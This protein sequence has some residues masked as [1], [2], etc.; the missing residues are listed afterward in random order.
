VVLM[1]L[2]AVADS[3]RAQ[4]PVVLLQIR[5]RAGDTLRVRLDQ[6]VEVG[7]LGRGATA[8]ATAT[9]TGTLV[10]HATL[11]IESVD[12]EGSTVTTVTDSVRVNTPPNSASAAVLS[13]AAAAVNRAVRFRIAP[14]GSASVPNS[15][16]ELPPAAVAAQM[17]ATLPRTPIAPGA[18]WTARMEVPMA[19][20]ADPD[21]RATLAATFAL[22]SLSRSGELAFISL[23]G[24]LIKTEKDARA[25]ALG[26]VE[27]SG[28]VMGQVLVDRRR[29]WITDARTTF[30]LQSL[31]FPVD[32]SK[33][34]VRVRMT[35]SQWMRAM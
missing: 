9:E 33:P 16:G 7:S 31:V 29:G 23:R 34:P 20:S 17:P 1:L 8:T 5:P 11:A 13:W 2:A 14:D 18:T 30:S 10:L 32:R 24:R 22:D 19:S 12:R 15:R 4:D 27:T 28:T 25:Q 21:G 26:V 35:I 6:S 3:G